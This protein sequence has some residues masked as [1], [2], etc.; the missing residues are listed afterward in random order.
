MCVPTLTVIRNILTE[1]FLSLW[2]ANMRSHGKLLCCILAWEKLKTFQ[3]KKRL[4]VAGYSK[5][6]KDLKSHL[7]KIKVILINISVFK[8]HAQK[9][10][11]ITKHVKEFK[12]IWYLLFGSK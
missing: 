2:V 10:A 8:K 1:L 4:M 7:S 3:H 6:K 9:Y 11:Y 5:S 12:K